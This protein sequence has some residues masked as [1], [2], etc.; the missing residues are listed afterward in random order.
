[1]LQ[2][3]YPWTLL[4]SDDTPTDHRR[5]QH[6]DK[7]CTSGFHLGFPSRGAKAVIVELR[8]GGKDYSS[9]LVLL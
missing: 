6:S 7:M 2:R 8:R 9:T 3:M 4:L 5:D 1:M